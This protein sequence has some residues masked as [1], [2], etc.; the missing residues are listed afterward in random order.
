MPGV[1]EETVIIN[2]D[3]T[4]LRG[5]SNQTIIKVPFNNYGLIIKASHVIV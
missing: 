4:I 5:V 3:N 2:I 1:Y